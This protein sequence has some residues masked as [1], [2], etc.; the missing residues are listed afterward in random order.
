VK[1]GK[2]NAIRSNMVEFAPASLNS[3]DVF[4]LDAGKVIFQWNGKDATKFEKARG[5]DIASNLR[6]KERGGNA[7]VNVLDEKDEEKNQSELDMKKL[8]EQFWTLL[9]G[10]PSKIADAKKSVKTQEQGGDDLSWHKLV[11]ERIRLY[12]I[13]VTPVRPKK[14]VLVN[15]P[16]NN[17]AVKLVWSH[18]QPSKTLLKS[19]YTYVLDYWTE[20]FI[21]VCIMNSHMNYY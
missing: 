9:A 11:D 17:I 21:W 15:K 1:G 12:R 18:S 7:K 20:L 4:V 3:G 6:V 16:F 10:S 19:E 14:G 2:G 5:L 8:W 13:S